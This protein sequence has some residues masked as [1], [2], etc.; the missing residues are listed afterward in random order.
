MTTVSCFL[1]ANI[2]LLN[3]QT[4]MNMQKWHHMC[5]VYVFVLPTNAM[6]N[7]NLHSFIPLLV[8]SG[9]LCL[10]LFIHIP[11]NQILSRK[12][13]DIN[14]TKLDTLKDITI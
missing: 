12:Y 4:Q 2:T 13:Q 3:I 10:I 9:T 14:K 5:S 8:K 11:A 1:K 6:V 7:S